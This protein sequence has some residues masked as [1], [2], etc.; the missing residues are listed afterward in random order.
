MGGHPIQSAPPAD[1]KRMQHTP[2]L[3]L[4]MG[5]DIRRS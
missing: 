2:Q 5:M 1:R 4:N 3:G